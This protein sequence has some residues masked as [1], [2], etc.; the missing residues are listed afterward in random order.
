MLP[1]EMAN[2]ADGTRARVRQREQDQA[3]DGDANPNPNPE[4]VLPNGVDGDN[5]SIPI[6][7]EREEDE[8]REEYSMRIMQAVS[9]HQIEMFNQ[10]MKSMRDISTEVK[11][12]RNEWEETDEEENNSDDSNYQ[13][14]LERPRI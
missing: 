6:I 2:V 4:V 7:P 1:A 9:Q 14:A 12:K 8:T 10:M 13:D 11:T 3:G 5:P